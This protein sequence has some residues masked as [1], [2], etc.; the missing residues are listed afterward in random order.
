MGAV[1][2]VLVLS[3][4]AEASWALLA[5]DPRG[6]FNSAG[7]CSAAAIAWQARAQE[8]ASWVASQYRAA[9]QQQDRAVTAFWHQAVQRAASQIEQARGARCAE[10]RP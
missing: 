10:G 8:G 9:L 4:S 1:V 3:V 6:S 7:A 2:L 5:P